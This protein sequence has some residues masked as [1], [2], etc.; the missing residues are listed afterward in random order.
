MEGNFSKNSGS[1]VGVGESEGV[2]VEAGG[3]LGRRGSGRI[4]A[5]RVTSR[6]WE[7]VETRRGWR[8]LAGE[9][10]RMRIWR[11]FSSPGRR[12]MEV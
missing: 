12:V 10:G 6:V 7:S 2:G 3:W 1:W 11:G 5:I 8:Y 4:S 9:V